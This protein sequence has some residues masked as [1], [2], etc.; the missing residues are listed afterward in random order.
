M[1]AGSL[2]PNTSH[3]C[4]NCGAPV[5]FTN[6]TVSGGQGE[7]SWVCS[8]C[9]DKSG[10]SWTEA[11]FSSDGQPMP[12]PPLSVVLPAATLDANAQPEAARRRIDAHGIAD[13]IRAARFPLFVLGDVHGRFLPQGHG[14][15]GF[16]WFEGR[17]PRPLSGFHLTY[18]GPSYQRVE[19]RIVIEQEDQESHLQLS[20]I[21]DE[22]RTLI[23]ARRIAWFLAGL[24]VPD[25]PSLRPLWE[26]D[27]IYQ[28]VNVKTTRQA[29]VVSERIEM[30]SGEVVLW[31][32][33]R[34]NAPL[35]IAHAQA[36]IGR[37]RIDVGAIG[38]AA[39]DLDHILGYL[40]RLT[41]ESEA[42]HHLSQGLQAWSAYL[43][44]GAEADTP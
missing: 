13:I 42:M 16:G 34:F 18:V 12:S 21:A 26:G 44:P 23:E 17:A 43:W 36:L 25:A 4:I 19:E 41:P 31:T 6:L 35:P 14:W 38:S 2:P 29:P 33:R 30:R 22:S 37:T 39:D 7:V 10:F 15:E 8:G 28:F 3:Y 40:T 5:T 20:W 9:G 11:S 24:P 32:I 1:T 27:S